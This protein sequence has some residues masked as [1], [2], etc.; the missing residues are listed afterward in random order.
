M[1]VSKAANQKTR[2]TAIFIREKVALGAV[3]QEEAHS[4]SN[5]LSTRCNLYFYKQRVRH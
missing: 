5:H 1:R 2:N 3:K 4:H